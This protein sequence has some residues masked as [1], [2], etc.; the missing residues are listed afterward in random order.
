V[1][2]VAG[3]AVLARRSRSGGEDGAGGNAFVVLAMAAMVVM[4]QFPFSAPIYFCF[5][6]PVVAVAVGAVVRLQ[7]GRPR[8]LDAS[9]LGLY[10]LY[11]VFDAN[12]VY[13]FRFGHAFERYTADAE[14]DPA[15]GHPGARLRRGRVP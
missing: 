6:A 14:L 3:T 4:V 12:P 13:V 10:L 7:P 5:A 1:A 11:G 9:V 2:I 15:R 8:L